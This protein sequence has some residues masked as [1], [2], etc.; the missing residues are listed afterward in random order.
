M[1]GPRGVGVGWRPEIDRTVEALVDRGDAEFVE[2][3]AEDLH[4]DALPGSLGRLRG[5]GVT[6]LPHAVSLSLGGAE[7]LRTD[8]VDHLGAVATALD[9]P[10]VS[11]HVCFVRAGGL[12]SGHLLPV[13]RTRDALDVVVENVRVAQ[14]RLPVPLAL[15]NIAALL[16][17]PDA[18][19]A[20]GAFLAELCARTDVG[21]VL[22]VANLHACAVNLGQDP[23]QVLDDLPLERVVYV[24]AAGGTTGPDGLYHDTHAH[25]LGPA[26][27][28][29]L[30]DLLAR[31]AA[32]GVHPGVLLER[33]DRYPSDGELAAELGLLRTIRD[34]GAVRAA[35]REGDV[36]QASGHQDL[37]G[38]HLASADRSR[39]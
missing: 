30:A 5:R 18:E 35:G 17:W 38:V 27:L 33:D 12:E 28:D 19:L 3:V 36:R 10:L 39:G 16:A 14:D 23:G 20:E 15:E 13:P 31:C 6:V 8:R 37:P 2:V 7:E 24:H 32:V 34:H 21:L 4:P 1:T 22:D 11:D 9:A 29:L 26:V 25:P